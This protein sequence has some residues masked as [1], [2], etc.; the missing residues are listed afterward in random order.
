MVQLCWDYTLGKVQTLLK[1]VLEN[2]KK[3]HINSLWLVLTEDVQQSILL[4][5]EGRGSIC[6]APDYFKPTAY[7]YIL[8]SATPDCERQKLT[9]H[10][11]SLCFAYL[12]RR[13]IN[14]F[15][16]YE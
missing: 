8:A 2:E 12:N 13:N 5:T 11:S 1:T 10:R 14:I 15:L 3:E 6:L 4:L 9:K 7:F 16:R